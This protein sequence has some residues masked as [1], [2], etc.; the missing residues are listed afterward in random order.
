MIQLPKI[1]DPRGNLSFIEHGL[2]GRCPFEIERVYWIYDVPAGAVRHPRALKH[3]TEMI[4]AMSGSFDVVLE[5]DNLIECIHLNRSDCGVV[6]EPGVIRSINNFSTN[7]VAMVLASGPYDSSEYIFCDEKGIQD[8]VISLE[9]KGIPGLSTIVD[10]SHSTSDVSQAQTIILP[11]IRHSNGS[12]TVA[13]NGYESMPFNIRRVF[14]LFDVPAD[15]ERGGHSHYNAREL[16]VA[17]TGS[18][19]V[20]LEDG[21]NPPK[22]FTLNR[23]YQGLYIPSGLWRTID[24]FSGAAVCM[25]LTSERYSEEDYVRDYEMFRKLTTKQ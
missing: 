3:T 22:R 15:A 25:V 16:I 12:L 21:K 5:H 2:N 6:V 7:S 10:S 17:L 4:V 18:F 8:D 11:R 24:N 1:E 9:D 13:E 14:Y 23:P 19:D 20:V